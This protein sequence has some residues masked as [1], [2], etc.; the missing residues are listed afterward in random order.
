MK[1]VI[2]VMAAA[3]SAVALADEAPAAGEQ[4]A[5]QLVRA[6][7][8]ATGWTRE[9][10]VA[11]LDRLDRWYQSNV[12]NA[13]FREQLNGA[14]V[15]VVTDTNAMTK[16]FTYTNGTV[17]VERFQLVTPASLESR[18]TAAERQARVEEARKRREAEKE[19]KRLDRIAELTTNLTAEVEKTMQAKNWPEE[20]ARLWL[21]QELRELQPVETVDAVVGPQGN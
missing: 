17:Y 11:G 20:L 18:L 6:V 16:T 2:L 15:S 7:E 13:K 4:D 14:V 3:A 12:G 9:E 10:L 8:A 1:K 19:K 5:A 21:L